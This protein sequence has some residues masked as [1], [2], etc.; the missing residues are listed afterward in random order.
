MKKFIIANLIFIFCFNLEA[1]SKE[2]FFEE[3]KKKYN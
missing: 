2:N 1:F 3:A